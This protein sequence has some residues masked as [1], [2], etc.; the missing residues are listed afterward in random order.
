MTL[1]R[2]ETKSQTEAADKER[3]EV[4]SARDGLL[5]RVRNV[6]EG[7][8]TLI[9]CKKEL[10]DRRKTLSKEK[11]KLFTV[12]RFIVTRRLALLKGLHSLFPIDRV[13]MPKSPRKSGSRRSGSSTRRS[14]KAESAEAARKELFSI[15]ALPLPNSS[16]ETFDEETIAAAL[17]LVA[18]L[19]LMLSKYLSVALRYRLV[20]QNSRTTIVDDISRS[21]IA[22]YPLHPRGVDRPRFEYGVFLLNKNIEQLLHSQGLNITTLRNTLPNLLVLLKT[23]T[24]PASAPVPLPAPP[25]SPPVSPRSGDHQLGGRSPSSKKGSFRE[26]FSFKSSSTKSLKGQLSATPS[27]PSAPSSSIKSAASSKKKSPSKRH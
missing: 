26:K 19:V 12:Q 14:K 2:G 17:A 23:A 13:A 21:A 5:P 6:V 25:L 16:F 27:T 18:Q 4:V 3:K 8:K 1:L 10:S 7:Q 20:Y 15:R 11:D 24:L 22:E 9:K